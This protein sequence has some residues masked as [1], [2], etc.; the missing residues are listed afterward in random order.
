MK[1]SLIAS[2]L[3][4]GFIFASAAAQANETNIALQESEAV[5]QVARVLQ[6]DSRD[7]QISPA[8]VEFVKNE[9]S[10]DSS[11]DL[12]GKVYIVWNVRDVVSSDDTLTYKKAGTSITSASPSLDQV[13]SGAQLKSVKIGYQVFE[14]IG[15]DISVEQNSSTMD[16]VTSSGL[17]IGQISGAVPFGKI[18]ND[19]TT[20][21]VGLNTNINVIKG[22]SLRLDLVGSAN[23]GIISLKSSA[24]TEGDIYNN[25]FGYT[26]G[27]EAGVRITHKSGL[28]VQTGV[29]INNKTLAPKTYNDGS[30]SS[31]NGSEKYVFVNV[32][33]SFGGK[34]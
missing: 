27:G 9:K 19:F 23:A 5:E 15:A 31:F 10:T 4:S 28:F 2:C 24:R 21:K 22:S 13:K 30:S 18:K 17:P 20:V 8:A 32:G 1:T 33:Y 14:H 29:G 26:V 25:A 16:I 12:K 6:V 34:K 3:I 11:L 7:I